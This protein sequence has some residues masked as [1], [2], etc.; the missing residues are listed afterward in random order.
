VPTTL[1]EQRA[2]SS[3][4]AKLN[5]SARWHHLTIKKKEAYQSRYTCPFDRK[6]KKKDLRDR[7]P[8]HNTPKHRSGKNNI[9]KS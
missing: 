2:V 7:D 8:E 1:S 9:T 3:P 5:L 4:G 6:H